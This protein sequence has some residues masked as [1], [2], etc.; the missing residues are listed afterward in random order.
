M[1]QPRPRPG[2]L[3][4]PNPNE[5]PE[6]LHPAQFM[7]PPWMTDEDLKA[8]EEAEAKAFKKRNRTFTELQQTRAKAEQLSFV[9]RDDAF[10]DWI[11][12][13]TTLATM[14]AEW[15]LASTL[16]ASYVRH[17]Q[18]YGRTR[19]QVKKSRLAIA[20]VTAW[21]RMMATLAADIPKTRR[22]KGWY[23]ALR[24]KRGA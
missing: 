23:Y 16:Y 22:T 7:N 3:P 10:S 8:N 19:P 6:P 1:E 15:T 13:C 14:P 2:S 12:R 24:L 5:V 18:G 21:G 17:A 11:R 4:L 9:V 20:T